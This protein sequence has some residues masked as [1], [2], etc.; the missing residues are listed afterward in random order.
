MSENVTCGGIG[1]IVL[2]VYTIFNSAFLVGYPDSNRISV[3]EGGA[4]RSVMI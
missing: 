1:S 2:I 4:L 3:V